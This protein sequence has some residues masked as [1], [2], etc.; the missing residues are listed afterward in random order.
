MIKFQVIPKTEAKLLKWPDMANIKKCLCKDFGCI[1]RG[2]K[3]SE[4]VS[5]PYGTICMC[6]TE[7]KRKSS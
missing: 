3:L 6:L 5:I 2:C 1:C 4:A 7:N